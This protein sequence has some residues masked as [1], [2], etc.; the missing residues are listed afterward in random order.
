LAEICSQLLF[1]GRK[2]YCE[3][4]LQTRK[5]AG[6]DGQER[7]VTE[8]VIDNMI[9]LSPPKG[10]FPGEGN[11]SSDDSSGNYSSQQAPQAQ[12]SQAGDDASA[13]EEAL[14]GEDDT[15]AAKP[16]AAAPKKQA[17]VE[18]TVDVDD[19]PF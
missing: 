1:K 15:P 7:V 5:W 13:M 17:P 19:I 10:G 18:D 2:I 8:I 14:V 11:Y 9:A 3:G 12:S 16:V 6:Q 4:R